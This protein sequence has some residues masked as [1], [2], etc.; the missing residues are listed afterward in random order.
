VL[1]FAAAG[2]PG[3]RQIRRGVTWL[4]RVQLADGSWPGPLGTGDVLA[5]CAAV[6][7]LIAAGVVATKVPVTRAVGWLLE[8]QNDSDGGWGES[9]LEVAEP[10]QLEP[11]R[12]R[13]AQFAPAH[14]APLPAAPLSPSVTLPASMPLPTAR[15][16]SALLAV[17][18]PGLSEPIERGIAFLVMSQQADGSW[19]APPRDA[20]SPGLAEA[21]PGGQPAIPVPALA[22]REVP[23][24]E[25]LT[26]ALSALGQYLE[27]AGRWPRATGSAGR[28]LQMSR[29]LRLRR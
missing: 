13:T 10:G 22:W 20:G 24:M 17:G 5:T 7:A 4:L 2:Q 19:A 8:R 14:S 25:A 27:G 23:E 1:A 28:A 11:F 6:A 16:I 29:P 26:A 9:R 3:S 21:A 12:S 15:A 18:D